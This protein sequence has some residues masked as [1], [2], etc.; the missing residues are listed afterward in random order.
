MNSCHFLYVV[1]DIILYLK[2][3]G[4]AETIKNWPRTS[5][6]YWISRGISGA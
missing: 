4:S 5:S 2:S 1:A 3:L 6:Q